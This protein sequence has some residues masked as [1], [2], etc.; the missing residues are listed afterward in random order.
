MKLLHAFREHPASVG[1][2]YGE[3]FVSAMG[4][5]AGL[6]KAALACGLHALFPFLCVRSGSQ[7]VSR[8]H[9]QMIEARRSS[10]DRPPE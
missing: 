6:A 2:T 7:A 4:F 3:H 1:K 5:A 8:L 9:R 10:A